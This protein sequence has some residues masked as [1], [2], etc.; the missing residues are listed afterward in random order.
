MMNKI[1]NKKE[2]GFIKLIIVVVI[3]LLLMRYFK[4][5]ISGILAYF[6]LT[7]S[8]IINWLKQALDWFKDLFNS[9]K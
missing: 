3:A 2:S 8:E 7:W 6:N 5:T 1:K 9:V 4:I